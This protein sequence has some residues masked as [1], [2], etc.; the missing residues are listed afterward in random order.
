MSPLAVSVS[1][2]GLGEARRL[3]DLHA[4]LVN[5]Y[6][7]ICRSLRTH[8]LPEGIRAA[9]LDK[10]RTPVWAPSTLEGGTPEMVERHLCPLGGAELDLHGVPAPLR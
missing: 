6:R 2:R 9:I 1:L 10:D 4:V 5:D 8:D 3:D 7:A